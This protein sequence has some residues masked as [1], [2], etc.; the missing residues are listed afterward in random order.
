MCKSW[1]SWS[2][3]FYFFNLLSFGMK[4]YIFIPVDFPKPTISD[5]YFSIIG[6]VIVG[7]DRIKSF[8]LSQSCN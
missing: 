6:P 1:I 3:E 5:L 4:L 2:S 7:V 8:P